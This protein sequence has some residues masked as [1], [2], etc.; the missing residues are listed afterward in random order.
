[1]LDVSCVNMS[2]V[3]CNCKM[4]NIVSINAKGLNSPQKRQLALNYFFKLKAHIVAIQ[5]TH[6]KSSAP[7]ILSNSRFPHCYM[8]NGPAKKAGVAILFA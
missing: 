5:E 6:F 4:V 7:P 3:Y 8:A 2:Q 1:M